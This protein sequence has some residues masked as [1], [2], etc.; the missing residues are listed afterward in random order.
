MVWKYNEYYLNNFVSPENTKP[1]QT[2]L[3][4]RPI[5]LPVCLVI[6]FGSALYVLNGELDCYAYSHS[7]SIL[8]GT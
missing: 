7:A 4:L 1:P 6:D 3:T 8:K 5:L 2:T